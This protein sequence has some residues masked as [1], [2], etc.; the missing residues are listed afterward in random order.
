MTCRPNYLPWSCHSRHQL[1]QPAFPT[2]LISISAVPSVLSSS[3]WYAA[4]LPQPILSTISNPATVLQ[5][6]QPCTQYCQQPQRPDRRLQ[7]GFQHDEQPQL[8]HSGTTSAV[9]RVPLL[10]Q[11]RG[12]L[13]R[14]LNLFTM[15][16]ELLLWGLHQ[17]LPGSQL[18]LKVTRVTL[19]G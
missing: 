17:P 7:Q 9:Q 11:Q 13:T 14:R 2:C 16:S 10:H 5:H 1:Q 4:I 6:V 3:H 15:L 8:C 18:P 19:P 12:L